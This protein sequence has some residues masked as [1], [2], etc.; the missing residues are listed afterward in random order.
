MKKISEKHLKKII[1]NP[2]DRFRKIFQKFSR[3]KY[4]SKLISKFLKK[5]YYHLQLKLNADNN[6]L[7]YELK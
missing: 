6:Y 7:L 5:N 2:I 4:Y 3:T 1:E